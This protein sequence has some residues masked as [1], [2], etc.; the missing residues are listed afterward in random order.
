MT[1]SGEMA[2][3]HDGVELKGR[4]AV[5]DTQGPHPAVM[6][7]HNGLGLNERMVEIAR[8]L[9]QRGY[10]AVATDMYGGG[11][12]RNDPAAAGR[13]M[14]DLLDARER[15]RAR[16]IAWYEQIKAR[17]DIDPQRIAAIGYCFGGLCVL[18]LARSGVDVK[19]VVS[20]HGLLTTSM[21]AK[22]GDVRG[23]VAIYA[24]GNDPY[25]PAEDIEAV[26]QELTA[27]GVSFQLMVFSQACHGFTDPDAGKMGRD[28]IEYHAIA[29]RVSWAGT[30]ALLETAL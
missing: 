15:L 22:P 14:V 11:D 29:D 25:A 7:M 3:V 12:R 2:F 28:G 16:A 17:P 26:R 19:A 21:P 6:V 20:Y 8:L 18:E 9:A 23:Q 5:P 1:D 10:A 27:A 24:G 13:A 4:I 30:M